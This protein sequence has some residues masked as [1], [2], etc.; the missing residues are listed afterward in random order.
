M[1]PR[2][3]GML[4]ILIAVFVTGVF[5]VNFTIRRNGTGQPNSGDPNTIR[6]IVK[7]LLPSGKV[8]VVQKENG[9]EVLVSLT[10]AS[11]ITDEI[12]ESLFY[13]D[14][15][16]GMPISAAGI[17]GTKDN[18]LIPSLVTVRLAYTYNG[19][20]VV[21]VPKLR[22]E[23]FSL[24][25]NPRLW[26]VASSSA[27]IRYKNIPDCHLIA[28][29]PDLTVSDKW[30][31]E[32]TERKIGG[33]VFKDT[34]Y[35]TESGALARRTLLLENPGAKYGLDATYFSNYLFQVVPNRSL[36]SAAALTCARAV[37]AVLETLKPRSSSDRI[38]IADPAAPIHVDRDSPI[39]IIGAA[40]TYD[41]S[42]ALTVVDEE[43]K[44]LFRKT[45][46]V[47]SDN[48]RAFGYF[49]AEISPLGPITRPVALRIFQ[50]SPTSGAPIDEVR[51]P[52]TI[53]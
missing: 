2:R 47:R 45:V 49:E 21:S 46:F 33:Q 4:L 42:I 52:M 11:A 5:V 48:T 8:I 1:S 6:G 22:Q 3:L 37:D 30:K 19:L 15:Q 26:D 36:P 24:V 43:D 51:L 7:T 50:Y 10:D 12:G 17:R 28:G 29:A 13:R 53:E 44:V 9:E 41:G 32:M 31:A 14:V 39:T 35:A 38:I 25:F 34:D 27:E 16:V 20:M 23:Y 18:V 40:R